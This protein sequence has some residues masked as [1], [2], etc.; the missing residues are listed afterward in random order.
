MKPDQQDP[1]SLVVHW[2]VAREGDSGY[3]PLLAGIR[4]V[5]VGAKPGWPRMGSW[6]RF[7]CG[8]TWIVVAAHFIGKRLVDS[9]GGGDWPYAWCAPCQDKMPSLALPP[10]EADWKPTTKNTRAGEA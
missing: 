5:E 1:R 7:A 9:A 4:V 8:R 2:A 3:E 6:Y 10:H